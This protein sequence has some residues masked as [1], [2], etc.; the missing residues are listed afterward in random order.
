MHIYNLA[1]NTQLPQRTSNVQSYFPLIKGMIVQSSQQTSSTM[2][3]RLRVHNNLKLFCNDLKNVTFELTNSF[4]RQRIRNVSKQYRYSGRQL[5][6]S[7]CLFHIP[8]IKLIP[9]LILS[10]LQGHDDNPVKFIANILTGKFRTMH[11]NNSQNLDLITGET[12]VLSLRK[13]NC[14]FD[15]VRMC[16]IYSLGRQ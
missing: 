13:S 2:W 7:N 8:R 10:V 15:N 9:R 14:K 12:S 1:L 4:Y 6:S 3:G 16:S 11:A 5:D